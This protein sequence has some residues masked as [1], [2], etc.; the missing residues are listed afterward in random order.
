MCALTVATGAEHPES[1]EV[2][3]T[4]LQILHDS[5]G[6][7]NFFKAFAVSELDPSARR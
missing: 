4:P 2:E 6:Q 5:P 7:G 3:H 1:A